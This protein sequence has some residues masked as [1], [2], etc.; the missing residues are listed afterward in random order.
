MQRTTRPILIEPSDSTQ[1]V[2][3]LIKN[4]LRVGYRMIPAGIRPIAR[5]SYDALIGE[6][7]ELIRY[8]RNNDRPA[9][10]LRDKVESRYHWFVDNFIRRIPQLRQVS[11][12]THL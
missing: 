4:L 12:L 9:Q 7:H 6:P 10:D 3:M 11:Y 1:S 8:Y 2:I 5:R